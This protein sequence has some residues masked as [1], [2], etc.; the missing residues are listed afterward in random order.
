MIAVAVA[1]F[2]WQFSSFFSTHHLFSVSSF[3]NNRARA[4]YN[5]QQL[6]LQT[7]QQQQQQQQLEPQC[8]EDKDEVVPVA[9][10]PPNRGDGLATSASS[11]S[12]SPSQSL[13]PAPRDLSPLGPV[14]V[15]QAEGLAEGVVG[16]GVRSDGSEDDGSGPAGRRS[17]LPP[18][19]ASTPTQHQEQSQQQQSQQQQQ[20]SRHSTAMGAAAAAA[21]MVAVALARISARARA[22][23]SV[24]AAPI[25]RASDQQQQQRIWDIGRLTFLLA[26]NGVALILLLAAEVTDHKPTILVHVPISLNRS[27]ESKGFFF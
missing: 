17:I 8:E 21:A 6:E 10:I 18:L 1:V 26:G 27:N 22:A 7:Q 15:K 23:A 13:D 20:R 16:C 14:P 19:L 5:R 2:S 24:L 11:S 12:P 9:T 4:V 3:V 25:I